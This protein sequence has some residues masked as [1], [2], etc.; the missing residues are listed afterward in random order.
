M[1]VENLLSRLEKV[2]ATGTGT[3]TGICPSHPDKS[4]SLAIRETEDG[5]VLIYCRAGCPTINILQAVGLEFS[6]LYPP[7]PDAHGIKPERRPFPAGDLLKLITLEATV[8]LIAARELL[9]AGDLVFGDEG[10]TRLALAADRI[11]SV[12]TVSG[13]RRHG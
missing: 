1:I 4:P 6:D 2:R 9:D 11:E 10:F 8:V 5:R 7:R 13:V 12:L 3:W